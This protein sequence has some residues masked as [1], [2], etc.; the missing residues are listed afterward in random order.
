MRNNLTPRSCF[1][2]AA[3]LFLASCASFPGAE[4]PTAAKTYD[5][6]FAYCAA[7]GN[8]DLP[9]QPFSGPLLPSV[10]IKGL[11]TAAG[12]ERVPADVL[13]AGSHWRCMDGKVYA[14]FTGANLPCMA[15]A[16]TT[17]TP[18]VDMLRFCT[19]NRESETIP[20]HV[21]GRFT[22]Y[23]WRCRNGLP[24]ALRQVAHPDARGFISEYWYEL[25]R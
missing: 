18:S 6:P 7:V 19:D 21:T 2:L 16:D 14:C 23:E 17:K 15:K 4:R 3:A 11:R 22:V 24:E 13:K 25:K 5:D 10:I 9:A 8:A 12:A 1:L 20:A